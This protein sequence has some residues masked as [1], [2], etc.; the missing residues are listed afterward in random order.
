MNSAFSN[1][2]ASNLLKLLSGS[3][4]CLKY[5]DNCCA[6]HD[7]ADDFDVDVLVFMISLVFILSRCCLGAFIQQLQQG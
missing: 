1:Q 7:D 5:N 3:I 6:H 4:A 2:F